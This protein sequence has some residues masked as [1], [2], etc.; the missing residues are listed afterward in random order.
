MATLTGQRAF[1]Q[2]GYLVVPDLF[3]AEECDRLNERAREM[4]EGRAPLGERNAVWLEPDAEERG[5]VTETNRYSM[6]FKIGHRMHATDA[7]FRDAARHPRVA[8]V[9]QQLIGPDVKCVQTM[10]IPDYARPG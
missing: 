1:Q 9:L 6:L 2:T 7:V 10:Y 3:T 4:V 5:L 8:F